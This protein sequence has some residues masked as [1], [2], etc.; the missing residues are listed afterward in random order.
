M[1]ILKK[2]KMEIK[3]LILKALG[4]YQPQRSTLRPIQFRTVNPDQPLKFDEWSK[5][6]NVS[7]RY[8]LLEDSTYLQKV[9]S[10]D[11][12]SVNVKRS[13]AS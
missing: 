4:W 8:S 11:I 5:R 9:R 1:L 2:I 3:V 7:R 6:F 10:N 12:S 13:L